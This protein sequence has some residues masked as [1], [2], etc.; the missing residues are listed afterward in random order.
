MRCCNVVNHKTTRS[1]EDND[2]CENMSSVSC[3]GF[4]TQFAPP[5]D[6]YEAIRYE[7]SL[8]ETKMMIS[9]HKFIH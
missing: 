1:T 9:F 2:I 4:Y 8:S 6:K 5:Y 3:K 7:Q